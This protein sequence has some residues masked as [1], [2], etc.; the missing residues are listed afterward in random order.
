MQNKESLEYSLKLIAKSSFIVLIGVFLSKIFTYLY[1]VIIARTFGQEIY[2]LFS[3]T[4]MIFGFFL[5]FFSLGLQGGLLRHIPFYR[6]RN[7]KNKIQYIFKI[8]F[9][10]VLL[11]SFIAGA[12]LFFL[13][14]Y[15]SLNIFH[16][17]GLVLFLKWFSFFIPVAIL[18]GTFHAVIRAYEKIGWYSFIGNILVTSLQLIFLIILVFFGLKEKAIFFSYNLGIL[19]LFI[20]SFFVSKYKTSEIFYKAKIKKRVKSEI[21][22]KL[23]SYSWPIMFLGLVLALF[24]WIDSFTI[25]Y[26]K[27]AADVGVYNAAVP[28]A[29]LLEI[30]PAL[31]LQLFFPLIT[32]EYSRKN[33]NLIK[34]LS[35][36]IVK[37]ILILNLPFAILMILFPGALINLLF[38]S[39]YIFAENS[40]RMLSIG[41][42]FYSIFIISENLL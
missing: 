19:S 10:T 12:L 34:K 11:T 9:L 29:V 14:D 38:G 4:L 15:I 27:S 13:S 37:W 3:L 17:P 41:V 35:K 32:R 5:A 16:N 40:L 24:S 18:G 8:S 39:E 2:G 21:T 22:K 31:F 20:A 1:K 33:L 25:G 30:S 26:F 23:F 28:I 7:E 6:G 42:L 36:Q